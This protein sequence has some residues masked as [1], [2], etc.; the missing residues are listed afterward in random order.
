MTHAEAVY[1]SVGN[2]LI[3]AG[4]SGVVAMAYSVYVQSAVRFVSRLYEGLVNGEDLAR[5]VA[6]GREQLRAL[7]KRR[8][9]IGEIDL[10]DWMVPILLEASPVRLVE[11]S[12][13]AIRLTDHAE[14]RTATAEVDCP[15]PPDYGFIGRDEVILTL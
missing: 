3:K 1:P 7:P 5:A 4:V 8:S 11:K 9:A 12:S 14:K 10:Q 13:Q 15:P 2:Q 6:L